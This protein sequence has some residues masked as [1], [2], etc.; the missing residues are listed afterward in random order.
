MEKSTEKIPLPTINHKQTWWLFLFG[1]YPFVLWLSHHNFISHSEFWAIASAKLFGEISGQ[2]LVLYYKPLFYLTLWPLYLF[3]LGNSEHILLSRMVY[4]FIGGINM[5]LMLLNMR[6][7]SR[8]HRITLFFAFFLISFQILTNNFFRVRADTLSLFFFLL[9]FSRI[10]LRWIQKKDP[11]QSDP[12]LLLICIG[13]FATTPKAIYGLVILGLYSITLNKESLKS[14]YKK[15]E[16]FAHFLLPVGLAL[17]VGGFLVVTELISHNPSSMAMRYHWQSLATLFDALSWVHI[18]DSLMINSSNYLI[19]GCGLT[20]LWR[21]RKKGS[22]YSG[23]LILSGTATLV[24][25]LHPEKWPYFLATYLPFLCFSLIPFLKWA[26]RR[27]VLV[28]A[29]WLSL[30]FPFFR[31]GINQWTFP[32]Q[33][34]IDVIE[35]LERDLKKWAPTKIQYYDSTGILPRFDSLMWF[36]GPNDPQSRSH[37][38]QQLMNVRPEFIF[39]TAK[40]RYGR[41]DLEVFLIREYVEYSSDYWV[42]KDYLPLLPEDFKIAKRTPLQYLF[43]FDFRPEVI[44]LF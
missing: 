13:A 8:S 32:N 37:T 2:S 28:G 25:L 12:W 33:R 4:G 6:W 38:I 27:K 3:D 21:R 17:V 1:F 19:L 24:I 15:G 5:T 30:L 22:L 20:F 11:S 29:L 34:Q 18:Q 36:L 40:L 35:G 41:P 10:N 16:H 23:L 31:I 39:Y 43:I 26:L 44:R 42:R 14:L 9:I 7:L